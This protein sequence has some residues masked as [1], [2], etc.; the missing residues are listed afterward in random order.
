MSYYPDLSTVNA[1]T[2]VTQLL[3]YC[4]TVTSGWFGPLTAWAFF[5][6]VF[7]GSFFAQ[8]RT[9]GRPKLDVCFAVAGFTS[10]GFS[11]LMALEFGLLR[12]YHVAIFI[13]IAIAGIA[14]IF[15]SQQDG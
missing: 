5:L 11:T 8:M 9:T 6:V 2:D 12:P 15:F 14:V 10:V 13:C 1:T 3:V 7:L 4:N